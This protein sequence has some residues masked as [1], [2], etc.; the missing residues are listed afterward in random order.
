MVGVQV[1][2]LEEKA[3]EHGRHGQALAIGEGDVIFGH[4][5]VWFPWAPSAGQSLASRRRFREGS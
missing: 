4:G 2:G 5:D 1:I 3:A